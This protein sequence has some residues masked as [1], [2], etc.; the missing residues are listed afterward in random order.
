MRRSVLW[1]PAMEAVLRRMRGE[2]AT[3]AA[4]GVALGLGRES[5]REHGRRL[6]V[7]RMPPPPAVVH[8][9]RNRPPLQ[10]GHPLTWGL[11]TQ[12]TCIEGCRY[13]YPVFL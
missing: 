13:P 6:G 10:A 1:T 2:G 9:D 8:E 4:I 7:R 12:G 11:L 3:W 5:V